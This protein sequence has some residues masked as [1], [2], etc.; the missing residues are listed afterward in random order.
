[1][2]QGVLPRSAYCVSGVPSADTVFCCQYDVCVLY[3]EA[4]GDTVFSAAIIQ[5]HTH[6]A[7]SPHIYYDSLKIG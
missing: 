4:R 6:T 3:I 7:H 2:C 5:G 1:M